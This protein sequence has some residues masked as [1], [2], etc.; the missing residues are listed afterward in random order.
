M[1]NVNIYN[2]LVYNSDYD[3]GGIGVAPWSTTSSLTHPIQNINFVNNTVYNCVGGGIVVNNP[4]VKNILI[5]NNILYQSGQA[6]RID[7]SVPASQLTIDRNLTSNPQFVNATTTNFHLQ[8][9]S[10]AID[11]GLADG[12]PGFD[13]DGKYRPT[14]FG[15][16]IGAF[17]YD[18]TSEGTNIMLPIILR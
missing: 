8:A 16:D 15:Y 7:P 4:E 6:L 9:T 13:F 18:G 2:N 10:P 11:S 3:W 12:A 17:E 14:S 1:E 5:R